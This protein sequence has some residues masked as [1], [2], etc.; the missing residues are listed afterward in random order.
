MHG[1]K[2]K[3]FGVP[4]PDHQRRDPSQVELLFVLHRGMTQNPITSLSF[5]FD[6]QLIAAGSARGTIHVFCIKNQESTITGT[7]GEFGAKLLRSNVDHRKRVLDRKTSRDIN[8]TTKI[9]N[10]IAFGFG[11]AQLHIDPLG[12]S[13]G[14]TCKVSSHFSTYLLKEHL[15]ACSPLRS[16]LILLS[17]KGKLQCYYFEDPNQQGEAPQLKIAKEWTLARNQPD[18]E[19][20]SEN[21]EQYNMLRASESVRCRILDSAPYGFS[22]SHGS[23]VWDSKQFEIL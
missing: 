15:V 9:H 1:N 8:S 20:F 6:D 3:L 4:A 17:D 14:K 18:D 5:S 23:K 13:T 16:S 22:H 12:T 19:G 10:G 2:I 7:D 21:V 11:A